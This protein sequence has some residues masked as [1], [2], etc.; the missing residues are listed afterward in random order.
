VRIAC[1]VAAL[2]VLC[3]ATSVS[4]QSN[5][6]YHWTLRQEFYGKTIFRECILTVGVFQSKGSADMRCTFNMT[7]PA[8]DLT[9]R[10]DLSNAEI[11]KLKANSNAGDLYGGGHTGTVDPIQSSSGMFETLKILCCD[12]NEV[13]ILVTDGNSSFQKDGPRLRLLGQLREV[14]GELK[15]M[16]GWP[17]KRIERSRTK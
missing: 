15:E 2:M 17:P 7:P 1:I 13:A 11:E 16:A 3:F 14:L 10:R 9:A 6:G 8:K 12:R 5:R 4:A